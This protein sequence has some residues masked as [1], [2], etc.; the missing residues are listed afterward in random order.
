MLVLKKMFKIYNNDSFWNMIVCL[1]NAFQSALLMMILSRTMGADIVGIWSIAFANAYLISNIGLYGVRTFHV[2][3]V[4]NIFSYN[5]FRMVRIITSVVMIVFLGL[6]N[7]IYLHYTD[8]KLN[9]LLGLCVFKLC[10][11]IEDLYHG[12]MQRKGQ[13][14]LACFLGS[15]RLVLFYIVFF[16]VIYCVQDDKWALWIANFV[17]VGFIIFEKYV[18]NKSI[19]GLNKT[20]YN[21]KFILEIIIACFPMFI[22]A[23]FSM[24]INNASKYAIDRI[25][26]LEEQALF[27]VLLMP[28]FTINLL[29]SMIYR[30]YLV[31]MAEVWI[32]N[33][34]L[35]FK[36]I[37]YKQI[38]FIGLITILITILGVAVGIKILNIL[39]KMELDKYAVE[40]ALLL[41]SGGFYACFNYLAA[42]I[43]I[44]RKQKIMYIASGVTMLV[45]IVVPQLLIAKAGLLGASIVNIILAITEMFILLSYILKHISI[46][47]NENID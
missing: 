17:M 16:V 45:A 43:S 27:S 10:E 46:K 32:S 6:Y 12:E 38:K 40:F 41:I 44:V 18:L 35:E 8:H 29:S 47:T 7:V 37:I 22:S 25:M 13:M 19:I 39:Y 21:K 24:Y 36:K 14:G 28:V 11:V 20:I 1:L 9:I 15:I 31:K 34:V 2:T 33:Q 30:P 23:F 4:E 42:C 3:D 5:D 26:T